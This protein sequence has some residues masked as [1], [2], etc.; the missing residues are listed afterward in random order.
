MKCLVV[1]NTKTGEIYNIVYN[2]EKIPEG[3]E[4]NSMILDIPSGCNLMSLDVS[5][6]PPKP[7]YNYWPAIDLESVKDIVKD[8]MTEVGNVRDALD[9]KSETQDTDLM[10]EAIVDLTADIC[11]LELGG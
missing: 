3:L 5:E 1:Y 9:N 6:D 11:N 2:E 8:A 4:N 10:L 7:N